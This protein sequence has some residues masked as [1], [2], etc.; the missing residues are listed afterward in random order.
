MARGRIDGK[1]DF[2]AERLIFQMSGVDLPAEFDV[3]DEFDPRRPWQ[4]VPAEFP[5]WCTS[6]ERRKKSWSAGRTASTTAG[7]KEMFG[8][9]WPSMMSRCSQ[10]A[11]ER[12]ARAASLPKRVKSAAS[13]EGAIIMAASIAVRHVNWLRRE[14][15]TLRTI[16]LRAFRPDT[17]GRPGPVFADDTA[18]AGSSV[19]H[20]V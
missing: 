12:S 4:T 20:P 10:S 19:P 15:L 2:L 11:P 16:D 18:F 3:D 9:K 5:A 8:T 7:P 6:D 13:S 17:A 1:A 14:D